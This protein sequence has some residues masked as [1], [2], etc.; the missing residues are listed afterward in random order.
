MQFKLISA[1]NDNTIKIW[2]ENSVEKT[3]IGHSDCIKSFQIIENK[4][5]LVSVSKDKT[6]KIWSIETTDGGKCLHTLKGHTDW[7]N[8]IECLNE[9]TIVTG[10]DDKTIKIWNINTLEC[11]QTLLGHCAFILCLKIIQKLIIISSSLDG[12]I[13]IWSNSDKNAYNCIK[14]I[15]IN[16]DWITCLELLDNN[17]FL[18]GS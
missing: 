15:R 11:E 6:I 1:S 2:N 16:K 13:K 8:C 12:T 18:S 7:I 14:T 17:R 5:L 3:L 4:N 10:S 9:Y